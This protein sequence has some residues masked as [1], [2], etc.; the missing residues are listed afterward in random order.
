MSS[1]PPSDGPGALRTQQKAQAT[2]AAQ[3]SCKLKL[4]KL[5]LANR[6]GVCTGGKQ[7]TGALRSAAHN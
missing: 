7:D 6:T 2:P 5:M 4:I 1:S 3:Y